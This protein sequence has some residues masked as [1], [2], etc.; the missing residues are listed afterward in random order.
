M[1]SAEK[2]IRCGIEGYRRLEGEECAALAIARVR[3][4]ISRVAGDPPSQ[5]QA[6]IEDLMDLEDDLLAA[7]LFRLNDAVFQ[8]VGERL[9]ESTEVANLRFRLA[10]LRAMEA[11][12]RA[13]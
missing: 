9:E 1:E 7:S 2:V 8:A 5:I 10:Y 4:V 12:E 11:R 6:V 13:S 3:V